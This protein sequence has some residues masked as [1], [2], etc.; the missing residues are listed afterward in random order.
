MSGFVFFLIFIF[1][2]IPIFK[3]ITAGSTTKK[4]VHKP[5]AMADS[6]QNNWPQEQKLLQEQ[7][8]AQN[9]NTSFGKR[10]AQGHSDARKQTR[11]RLRDG[12]DKSV[13][14]ESHMAR[15]RKRDQRDR[16]ERNRIEAM[17]HSQKNT[18]IIRESNKSVDSWGKRG[19]RSSG[20]GFLFLILFGLIA[21]YALNKM[22]PDLWSEIMLTFNIN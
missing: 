18:S 16:S 21:I 8:K 4:T 6:G 12:K 14:P 19:D 9:K 20:G 3:N 5:K 11:T 13:F 10:D 22:A 15:V 7:M 2:I 17:L 1:V